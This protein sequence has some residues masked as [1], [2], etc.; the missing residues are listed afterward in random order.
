MVAPLTLLDP[1][2]EEPP[3]LDPE[4]EEPL[5]VSVASE[6]PPSSTELLGEEEPPENRFSRFE[7]GAG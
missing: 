7:S 1:E 2:D 6:V 4:D 3:L 5:E